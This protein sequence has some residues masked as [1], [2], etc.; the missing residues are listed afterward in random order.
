MKKLKRCAI[1]L[2][3]IIVNIVYSFLGWML[4]IYFDL[5]NP[6]SEK[7]DAEPYVRVIVLVLL[8]IHMVGEIA[9]LIF[10]YKKV[11]NKN[12]IGFGVFA[13]VNVNIYFLLFW[14]G[15]MT[16]VICLI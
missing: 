14:I 16:S 13:F 8:L 2:L 9:F 10:N 12:K 1:M 15:L 5:T 6:A 4:Y 3:N 11:F 7:F